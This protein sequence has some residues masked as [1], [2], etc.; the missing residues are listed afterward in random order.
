MILCYVVKRFSTPFAHVPDAFMYDIPS[1]PIVRIA[2]CKGTEPNT[3]HKDP[4]RY[5]PYQ[6]VEL[7][8]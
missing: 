2:M 1:Q 7:P 5:L 3:V 4:F 8:S 6:K